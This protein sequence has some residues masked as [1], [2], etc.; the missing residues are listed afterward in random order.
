MAEDRNE[1][2][3]NVPRQN[4]KVAVTLRGGRGS[5]LVRDLHVV[6]D[7]VEWRPP[8][9]AAEDRNARNKAAIE[10]GSTVAAALRGGRGSQLRDL[11]ELVMNGRVAAAL[12]GGRGSQ[13]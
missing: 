2:V 1:C 3:V 6:E 11:V 10:D 13:P 4:G 8:F 9:G 5:P 7:L 12:R